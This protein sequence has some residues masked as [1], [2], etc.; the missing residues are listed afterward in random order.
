M[1]TLEP[2]IAEHPFFRGLAAQ[3]LQLIVGCAKNIRFKA[4]EQI[5]R[6]GEDAN[7]FYLIRRGTVVLEVHEPGRQPI[8]IQ[9]I[10][11]GDVLGWA[12]LFEPYKWHFSAKALEITRALAFDGVCLRTKC[13]EDHDL[14]YEL[15]KRFA[16]IITQRLQA[17]RLQMLDVFGVHT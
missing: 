10:G 5:F 17:T 12:W 16:N 3:Y 6:E 11:E 1:Q 15:M 13:D 14:G 2:I 4:D 7:E 8:S 9:T